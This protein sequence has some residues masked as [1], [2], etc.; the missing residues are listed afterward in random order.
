MVVMEVI[1]VVVKVVSGL[2]C[3]NGKEKKW[4]E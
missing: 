2:E 3:W 4:E 1:M